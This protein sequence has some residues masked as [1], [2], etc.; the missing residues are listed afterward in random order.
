MFGFSKLL[1]S[2]T[3]L[4]RGDR[5]GILQGL[6]DDGIDVSSGVFAVKLPLFRHQIVVGKELKTDP[7]EVVTLADL[8]EQK[9]L[10]WSQPFRRAKRF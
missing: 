7:E 9:S 5:S 8:R 4:L 10:V 2:L 6:F 1:A 3:P